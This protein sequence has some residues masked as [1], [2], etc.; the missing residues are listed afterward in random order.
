VVYALLGGRVHRVVSRLCWA[1]CALMVVVPYALGYDFWL[2]WLMWFG[3][4]FFLGLGHPSTV[5][6]HTRLN[7][8]RG[9]MAWATVALFILTFSPVPFSFVPP[10]QSR[11]PQEQQEQSPSLGISVMLRLPAAG[12]DASMTRGLGSKS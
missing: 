5:D 12:P 6:A 4:V 10:A 8:N 1:G 9:M 3:L 2:G 11:P 7:G